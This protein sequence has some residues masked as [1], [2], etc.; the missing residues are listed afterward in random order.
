MHVYG[1][2]YFYGSFAAVAS[3]INLEYLRVYFLLY[4][5]CDG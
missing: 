3:V 4:I 5:V 2:I 1:D